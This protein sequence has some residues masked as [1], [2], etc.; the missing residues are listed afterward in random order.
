MGYMGASSR[1]Q[2]RM[3]GTQD[4]RVRAEGPKT[5][6]DV[7]TYDVNLPLPPPTSLLCFAMS[8]DARFHVLV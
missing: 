3:F 6:C 8:W 1:G 7:F 5:W 2:G 4:T